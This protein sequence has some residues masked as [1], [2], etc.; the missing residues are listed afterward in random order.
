[1]AEAALQGPTEA[2][3][4]TLKEALAGANELTAAAAEGAMSI[5]LP[6]PNRGEADRAEAS[7]RA[8]PIVPLA[9]RI[10]T[11][12]VPL[13]L[14]VA[15]YFMVVLALRTVLLIRSSV[16]PGFISSL[17][18]FSI[19]SK[20]IYYVFPL[21]YLGLLSFEG[22]YVKRFP[23]WKSTERL[24]RVCL[25]AIGMIVGYL[26]L[27]KN[28]GWASRLFLVLGGPLTFA[29]LA[30]ARYVVKKLL[31][32][33]GLWDKPVIVVGAGKTAELLAKGFHEDPYIGYRI[34]GFIEDRPAGE[35]GYLRTAAS[36][37]IIG[38]FDEI[39]RVLAET[40]VDEVIIAAPG[41]SQDRLVRLANRIQPLVKRLAVVPNL[42]GMPLSN[43]EVETLFNQKTILLAVKNNLA[44]PANRMGKRLFD[45]ILGSLIFIISAPIMILIALAIRLDSRGPAFFVGKRI[46]KGGRE[47]HCYKF[48]SMYV[49]GDAMLE[50]F[51]AQNA[52]AREDWEKYAKIKTGDPRVTR[53]G[54]VMRRFSLDEL[55]QILNVLKG[56]MSLVGP[57]PYLPREL[58]KMGSYYDAI[59]ETVPGVTGLWQ[60]SGRN[61]VEFEG[62]LQMDE[63]YVRN[64]SV[65]LDMTMLAKTVK[66]VLGRKG[67]F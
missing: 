29:Y 32:R 64:W 12:L 56:E 9:A 66:V 13:V 1:M 40:G 5:G 3:G 65:W 38:R 8:K 42:F 17:P 18:A 36:P 33:Y 26:F 46:G 19:E 11:W 41:L 59:V 4:A 27:T 15:D 67:A 48:R 57:R 45:L 37:P 53:V 23:I 62:R 51:F 55:P 31:H 60:V 10:G 7:R 47:F 43:I 20:Y 63:W 6:S 22:L 54:R 2:G 44:S 39:E 35:T 14:L 21:F 52:A 24:F 58:R 16:L 30:S 34:V 61:D 25:Y 28:T 49:N 50:T